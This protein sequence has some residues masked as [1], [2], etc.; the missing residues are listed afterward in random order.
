MSILRDL[1]EAI[2]HDGHLAKGPMIL[3]VPGEPHGHCKI[4]N[5]KT[6]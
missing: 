3:H 4:Y 5:P 6:E 1:H 2:T